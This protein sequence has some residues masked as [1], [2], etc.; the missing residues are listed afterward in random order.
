M[1]CAARFR[2][3]FEPQF[4]AG[5]FLALPQKV[6]SL[7]QLD[8]IRNIDI[9]GKDMALAGLKIGWKRFKVAARD[10]LDEAVF[11]DGEYE[12]G[13]L[14]CRNEVIVAGL[15][16]Q[17]RCATGRTRKAINRAAAAR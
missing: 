2:T 10:A 15:S 17:G 5:L 14:R 13:H 16:G 3:G 9:F 6:E 11:I 7:H 12:A 4:H 8:A 1:N